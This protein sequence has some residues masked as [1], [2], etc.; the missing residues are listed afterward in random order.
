[1]IEFFHA[2]LTLRNSSWFEQEISAELSNHVATSHATNQVYFL[3][4]LP[5]SRENKRRSYDTD[6]L[7]EL[8]T[9]E[10]ADCTDRCMI[11]SLCTMKI[12]V[13]L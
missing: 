11:V 9:C 2:Y 4:N 5:L 7:R 10:K 1:M 8:S 13:I 12:S 3:F 6:E